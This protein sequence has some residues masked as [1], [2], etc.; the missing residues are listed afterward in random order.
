L[1]F[2]R[3]NPLPLSRD[4]ERGNP[5]PLSRDYERGNPLP[6]SRD[7]EPVGTSTGYFIRGIY[8]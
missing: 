3:G 5:L 7:Y 4:Y 8:E 2:E 6:L 1:K